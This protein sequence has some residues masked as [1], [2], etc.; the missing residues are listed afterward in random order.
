MSEVCLLAVLHEDMCRGHYHSQDFGGKVKEERSTSRY[1][2]TCTF[3]PL[4]CNSQVLWSGWCTRGLT[5]QYFLLTSF[6]LE[7]RPEEELE[8]PKRFSMVVRLLLK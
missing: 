1:G 6:K 8:S 7:M 3:S 4:L 2:E 5:A